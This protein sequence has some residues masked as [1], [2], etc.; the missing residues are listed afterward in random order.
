MSAPSPEPVTVFCLSCGGTAHPVREGRC[1]LCEAAFGRSAPPESIQTIV[2][3][4]LE[5]V[6]P[7]EKEKA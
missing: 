1:T 4:V 2:P 3:R 7:A 6:V 5:A